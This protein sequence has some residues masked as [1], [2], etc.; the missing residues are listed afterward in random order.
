MVRDI[1]GVLVSFCCNN[2]QPPN[3]H[4]LQQQTLIS[5]LQLYGSTRGHAPQHRWSTSLFDASHILQSRVKEEWVARTYS[6]HAED[7]SMKDQAT[8]H[9]TYKA[10][11]LCITCHIHSHSRASLTARQTAL[12]HG[13][14]FL[15]HRGRGLSICRK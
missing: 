11:A 3:L 12:G 4:G 14:I 6:S 15:P 10:S 1:L 9:S 5:H 7:R 2:K 8:S 13:S